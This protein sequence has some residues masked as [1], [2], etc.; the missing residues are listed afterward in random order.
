MYVCMSCVFMK[1]CC[2]GVQCGCISTVDLVT[3]RPLSRVLIVGP[4]PTSWALTRGLREPSRASNSRDTHTY[5]ETEAQQEETHIQYRLNLYIHTRQCD[6]YIQAGIT[7]IQGRYR[8]KH[9]YIHASQSNTYIHTYIS[10]IQSIVIHTQ[11]LAYIATY[12]HT[13]LQRKAHTYIQRI[14]TQSAQTY[15][16]RD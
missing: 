6:T 3:G 13:S 2:S 9:R 4:T 14:I 8:A 5:R 7:Y 16:H 15:I 11:I 1:R 10:Q 12:I